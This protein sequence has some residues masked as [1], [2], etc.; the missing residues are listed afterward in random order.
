MN[1]YI[2]ATTQQQQQLA[3]NCKKMDPQMQQPVD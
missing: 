3:I 2:V 1:Q